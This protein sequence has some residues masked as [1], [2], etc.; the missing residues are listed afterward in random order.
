MNII[1]MLL[2]REKHWIIEKKLSQV[3]FDKFS[4]K[5]YV[6]LCSLNPI[7]ET[8]FADLKKKTLTD[9]V[10]LYHQ[11]KKDLLEDMRL[12]AVDSEGMGADVSKDQTEEIMAISCNIECL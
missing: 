9:M 11:K 4:L 3:S 6:L 8:Y 2:D 7:I 5:S 10:S 1:L 12:R